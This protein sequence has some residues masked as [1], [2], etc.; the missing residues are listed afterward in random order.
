[1]ANGSFDCKEI[2]L[3]NIA[4]KGVF[5][6]ELNG[7]E[8]WVA[9]GGYT[10]NYDYLFNT[11]KPLGFVDN[12]WKQFDGINIPNDL[13]DFSSVEVHPESNDIFFGSYL[14][15]LVH[16]TRDENQIRLNNIYNDSNSTLTNIPGD[17]TRTRIGDLEF[18]AD[19]NLWVA[20]YGSNIISVFT[21]DSEWL[22]FETDVNV[23][24]LISLT[25]DDN[26]YKWFIVGI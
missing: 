17:D 12:S 7:E 15:G 22:G 13:T 19:N 11:T 1:M 18:D 21:S 5:D 3:N 16:L 8:I 24:E 14:D 23:R 9:A 26:G 10:T 2:Y 20:N 4:S 6:I 25:I